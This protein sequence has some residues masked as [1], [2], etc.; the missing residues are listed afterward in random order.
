[1]VVVR[2]DA[3]INKDK[4]TASNKSDQSCSEEN[5]TKEISWTDIIACDIDETSC[6]GINSRTMF[7]APS[8]DIKV[9]SLNDSNLSI[10]VTPD[11]FIFRR[12]DEEVDD[13]KDKIFTSTPVL[14]SPSSVSNGGNPEEGTISLK[15]IA[16]DKTLE[17]TPIEQKS[18]TDPQEHKQQET[19]RL[20]YAYAV[21]CLSAF[22]IIGESLRVLFSR[23]FG[24]EC[25]HEDTPWLY[26]TV[27]VANVCVTSSGENGLQGGVFFLDLPANMLGSFLMGMLL[28]TRDLGLLNDMPIAFLNRGHWYQSWTV[29]HLGLRTGFCG[30]LTTFASWNSQMVAMIDGKMAGKSQFFSAMFG[31]VIGL[32]A[33]MA[34]LALGRTTAIWLHR[35]TNSDF[36][37]EEDF[38]AFAGSKGKKSFS[39][40][41]K[42]LPDYERRYLASLVT[43]EEI[44]WA[45]NK[46]SVTTLEDL[47][48]WKISTDKYRLSGGGHPVLML[49]AIQEI[50]KKVLVDKEEV[51]L[52]MKEIAE[53][54]GWDV[55]ALQKFSRE[56]N[57]FSTYCRPAK[58]GFQFWQYVCISAP[59]VVALGI[60]VGFGILDQM[61]EESDLYRN[62][63]LNALFAPPGTLIRWKLSTLNG[64]LEGKWKW[65]PLGTFM[66]N[67][68][69]SIISALAKGLSVSMHLD[70]WSGAAVAAVKTGFA[71]SMST[72]STFVVE[73]WKI[74]KTYGHHAKGY[75]YTLGSLI[76]ACFLGLIVYCPIVYLI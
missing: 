13:G 30:A 14:T 8:E 53:K 21:L 36:A 63:W 69:A 27:T 37:A 12:L 25:S 24:G 6:T 57:D 34:S 70:G 49:C 23:F 16:S 5:N 7:P 33:A 15:I 38:F 60:L 39:K 51:G 62:M 58:S 43:D 64:K 61:N 59:F 28:P 50:E 55:Q 20:S 26:R 18:S 71:G 54:M 41:N 32:E 66:T 56:T 19:S 42:V 44:E 10:S 45:K 4:E 73:G 76:S 48:R 2:K 72:V 75:Y 65:F 17:E 40:V 3:M 46:N 47:E 31:Y 9:N 67:M 74:E 35:Y 11:Q 22:S 1:M 68:G 52:D 29:T